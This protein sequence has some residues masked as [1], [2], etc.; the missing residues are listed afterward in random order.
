MIDKPM[1]KSSNKVKKGKVK[2]KRGMRFNL[3]VNI[4]EENIKKLKK[5]YKTNRNKGY[6][7]AIRKLET[8]QELSDETSSDAEEEK[9]TNTSTRDQELT[10][11]TISKKD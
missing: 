8:L 11:S 5:K 2:T 9:I 6:S 4:L 1:K 3:E 10:A 7:S